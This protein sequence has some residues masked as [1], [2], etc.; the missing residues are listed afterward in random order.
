MGVAWPPAG[1]SNDQSSAPVSE[2]NA[3]M[4]LSMGAA[5]KTRPPAVAIGPP[6][7]MVPVFWP[8]MNEPSGESQT[9]F[10]VNRST[11]ETVPQGGALQGVPF[12][13][14]SGSRNIPNGAPDCLPNSAPRRLY[15][16]LWDSAL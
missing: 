2:S 10:P 8:G 16:P 7:V 3:R 14:K 11:A 9:F 15:S 1:S 12:G 5:V 4:K 13:E 6:S